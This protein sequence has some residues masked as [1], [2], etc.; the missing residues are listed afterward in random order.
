MGSKDQV[1]VGLFA[2]KW[3]YLM[4]ELLLSN[5]YV[6]ISLA[7]IAVSYEVYICFILWII[8]KSHDQKS[9]E[10][11]QKQPFLLVTWPCVKSPLHRLL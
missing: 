3:Y 9:F 1:H 7:V 2:G 8:E 10:F 11:I 5:R 6:C 4:Y